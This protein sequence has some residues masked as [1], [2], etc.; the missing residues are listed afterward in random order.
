MGINLRREVIK[1][2]DTQNAQKSRMK[3]C[4]SHLKLLKNVKETQDGW[5]QM[6]KIKTDCIIFKKVSS[7]FF[8]FI[9]NRLP[10]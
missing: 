7:T 2:H 3:H 4:H 8:K 6:D 5:T 10:G 1:F 9:A